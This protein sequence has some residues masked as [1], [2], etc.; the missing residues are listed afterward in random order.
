MPFLMRFI[1]LSFVEMMAR[2]VGFLVNLYVPAYRY[3]AQRKVRGLYWGLRLGSKNLRIGQNV[4]IE[5]DRLELGDNI[6]LYDGGQYMTGPKGKIKIGSN[7][8]VARMSII[9]GA[10]SVEIGD[11][12]SISSHVA[13][14]SL[15]GDI[16]APSIYEAKPV[17]DPV[18]IGRNV[19]MGVGSKVIPGVTIGAGSVIAAGAV[20][21]RDVPPGH[22]AKGV[23]AVATPLDVSRDQ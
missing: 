9:S 19:Y 20:V 22:L 16:K 3:A 13:I 1:P 15:G 21:V 10:G 12:C 18:K 7:C 6:T 23:P 14:Y 5:S 17:H 11:G 8:H 4:I 2:M